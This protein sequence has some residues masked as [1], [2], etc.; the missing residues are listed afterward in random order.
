MSGSNEEERKPLDWFEIIV[1]TLATIVIAVL[2][3]HYALGLY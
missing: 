3:G 2:L 1:W